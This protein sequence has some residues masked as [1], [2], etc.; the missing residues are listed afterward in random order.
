M[1][2]AK[3][4]RGHDTSSPDPPKLPLQRRSC[5]LGHR[6]NNS[7]RLGI[8]EPFNSRASSF[9]DRKDV[10]EHFGKLYATMRDGVGIPEDGAMYWL[11]PTL[12]FDTVAERSIGDHAEAANALLKD[13]NNKEFEIPDVSRL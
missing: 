9:G 1:S 7:Y 6:T 11:G 2:A 4:L 10:A 8:E 3:I 5:V 13:P 12:S